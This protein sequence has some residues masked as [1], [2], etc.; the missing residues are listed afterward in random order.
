MGLTSRMPSDVTP[1]DWANWQWQL[2]NRVQ[3]AEALERYIK[4][5]ELER[6]GIAAA[7]DRYRWTI[8]PHY[9]GLMDPDD[10][11]CPLRIQQIPALGELRDDVGIPDP[12]QER[13][14]SPVD[15]IVH[16]YPDRIA[17]KVTNICPTYCRY[18]FR[19]YFVGNT[20]EHH[21]R[22]KLDEG[23]DYIRRTPAIRDVLLTGGDPFLFSDDRL[24]ELISQ[25]R[26]IPHVELIRVGTRTPCTLPQRVTPDLCRMLEKYHPIW[27][28]THFNHPKEI[29]AEATEACDNLLRAGIPVGNQSVLLKGVNDSVEVMTEL[30]HQLLKIRVR[31]YYIYQC[32]ILDGTAH[33]RTSIEKGLEIIHGLRGFTTGFGV[34]TYV[35]DTPYGKVPLAPQYILGRD[36]DDVVMRTFSG[37]V[38]REPNP[39]ALD[40]LPAIALPDVDATPQHIEAQPQPAGA[41]PLPEP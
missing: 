5:T 9:A 34:P 25:L 8:T 35:L 33:L 7:G 4:L 31:P 23:I 15:A 19:E 22:R 3:T 21:T 18:C 37:K 24:E 30:V 2:R 32:Q 10:P 39:V 11:N 41:A 1:E 12:L 40:E 14:N 27:L 28:N 13:T 36:G 6:R 20:D 29:T 17:F 16:V 26:A 38:W